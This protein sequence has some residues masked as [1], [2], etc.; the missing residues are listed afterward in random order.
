MARRKAASATGEVAIV[1][2]RPYTV[3]DD[4]GASYV[5]GDRI[6]VSPASA[7]HFVNRH[8]AE[9]ESDTG[10]YADDDARDDSANQ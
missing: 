3:Q 1:F 10:E 8:V 4:T 7:A 6:V 9:L 2:T 5:R